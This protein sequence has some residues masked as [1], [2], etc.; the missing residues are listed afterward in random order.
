MIAKPRLLACLGIV[1]LGAP[2]V[3]ACTGVNSFN[4]DEEGDGYSNADEI[5][6]GTDPCTAVQL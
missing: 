1:L 2:L 4:I 6:I 3:L 5:A